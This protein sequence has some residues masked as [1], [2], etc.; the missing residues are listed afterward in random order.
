MARLC[1]RS[2][3]RYAA[4]YRQTTAR[5]TEAI[6]GT[7]LTNNA[8]RKSGAL[9]PPVTPLP[10]S[11]NIALMNRIQPASLFIEKDYHA[12]PACT[13]RQS[14]SAD[15]AAA[16]SMNPRYTPIYQCEASKKTSSATGRPIHR[17]LSRPHKRCGQRPSQ[18]R[19]RSC[20]RT[21]LCANRRCDATLSSF[22]RFLL[23]E[24]STSTANP[25]WNRHQMR[26]LAVVTQD[27][28]SSSTQPLRK[29]N[30]SRMTYSSALRSRGVRQP[31]RQRTACR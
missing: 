18:F 29:L 11:E 20:I 3:T 9:N 16:S 7:P 8:K 13:A 24:N 26:P 4:T 27:H 1:S 19:V 6:R 14:T 12:V 28:R 31:D 30:R 22:A 25:L 2:H 10:H 23:A 17:F 5:T 15:I 21:V